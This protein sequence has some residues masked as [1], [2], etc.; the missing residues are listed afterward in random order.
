MEIPL[1]PMPGSDARNEYLD[2][3]MQTA[4]ARLMKATR[5]LAFASEAYD[6]HLR[7]LSKNAKGEGRTPT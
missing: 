2:S 5:E 1:D 4:F 7:K 6:A 3:D